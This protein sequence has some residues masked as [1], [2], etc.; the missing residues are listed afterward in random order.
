MSFCVS[1]G[2]S[3]DESQSFCGNCGIEIKPSASNK[4][5]EKSP[6]SPPEAKLEEKNKDDGVSES[7]IKVF[8]L[9]EEAGGVKLPNARKLKVFDRVRVG[10]S[11]LGFLFGPIYYLFKGMWQKAITLTLITMGIFTFVIIGLEA[12]GKPEIINSLNFISG[13][14]FGVRGKTDYYKKVRLKDN[15]WL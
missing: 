14:L 2:S 8:N 5:E 6:Y 10:V 12:L 15:G 1:C 11:F 9:I 3:I 7:W 13:I 4:I